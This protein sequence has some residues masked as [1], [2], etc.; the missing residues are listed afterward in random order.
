M[1]RSLP[2]LEA[3]PMNRSECSP[4]FGAQDL[5]DVFMP[6]GQSH[7]K[8]VSPELTWM[9]SG[10]GEATVQKLSR[11]EPARRKAAGAGAGSGF[12]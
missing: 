1:G 5:S 6:F 8:L 2:W 3:P 10:N 11:V 9:N 7:Q 4:Q 12:V